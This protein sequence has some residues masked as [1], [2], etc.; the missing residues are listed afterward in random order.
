MFWKSRETERDPLVYGDKFEED[1]EFERRANY[2][3][4]G[5]EDDTDYRLW[6][7]YQPHGDTEITKPKGFHA[8]IMKGKL[9]PVSIHTEYGDSTLRVMSESEHAPIRVD[10][11]S[12]ST[13]IENYFNS[14]SQDQCT[15]LINQFGKMLEEL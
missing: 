9:E 1:D 7:G 13:R 8:G 4:F 11:F 3:M 14:L 10:M 5:S 12:P 15:K 6:M 2:Y